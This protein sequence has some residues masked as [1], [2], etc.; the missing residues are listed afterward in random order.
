M[1]LLDRYLIRTIFVYTA[2]VMGV[3]LT[4]DGLFIFGQQDDIG[5][6]NYGIADALLFSLLNLPQ[7][8]FDLMPIGVLLGSLLG[9]GTLARGSELVVVR[10][11]GVSILRIA[12]AIALGGLFLLLL[13]AVLGEFIAPPLQ[14]FARQQKVFSKFSD[15]SIAGAGG[16]WVKDGETMLN[17]QE[18]SGDALFGSVYVFRFKGPQELAS[19]A[20][21][22][23]AVPQGRSWRLDRYAE[24]RFEEGRVGAESKSSATLAVSVDSTFLDVAMSQPRQLPSYVLWQLVRHLQANGL[25]TRVYEFA[26][27]SRLARTCAIVLVALLAIP[28][29]FGSL[30]SSGAGARFI[31]GVLI[32]V[33]FF[34]LQ[35][36]LESGTVVFDLN[37]AVLA[38]LPTGLLALL[39]GVLIARTR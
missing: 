17:V 23:S 9:L 14:K 10:A 31:V 36:T 35:R 11:S 1:I 33:G 12:R 19:V 13:T 3:L 6:G 2:M 8:A 34:F 20:R 32:G 25:E 37:P 18:Q 27:W 30:R 16:A 5:V 38:W 39:T 26:F 4:L 21:A 22:A 7:E 28:F 24:T 15:V 29:C